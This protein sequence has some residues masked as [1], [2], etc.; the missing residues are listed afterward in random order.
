MPLWLRRRAAHLRE[1]MDDPA[2]DPAQLRATYAHFGTVNRMVSGWAT[3]YRRLLRPRMRAGRLYRLLDIGFGGG[4]I[5]RALLRWAER[6]GFRLHVTAIDPDARAA[7]FARALPAVPNLAF[8]QADTGALRR[9]GAHFDFVVSNHLLHHLADTD[10]VGLCHD[11]AALGTVVLH[12][13]IARADL[14]YLGFALL[15]GPFF[16]ESLITPDGLTSVR[17]AYTRTELRRVV[18]PG[19]R[20][21]RPH[22]F[23]L[24]LS[25][26]L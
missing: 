3:L 22:P 4:D 14:A 12:N 1:R 18:P 7:S 16:R 23:R 21:T 25:R 2:C 20:V 19:W 6:D 11:S 10:V 15:T 24:L 8:E 5:P 26:G 17:R 9:R 13:D